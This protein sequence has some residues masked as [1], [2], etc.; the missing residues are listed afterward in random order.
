MNLPSLEGSLKN[1]DSYRRSSCLSFIF[2]IIAKVGFAVCGYLTYLSKTDQEITS[3]V[4]QYH[5]LPTLLRI[6]VMFF[7]YFTIPLQSYVV[8]ELIDSQ[9]RRKFPIW[10]NREYTWLC[11][12]RSLFMTL[13]LFVAVVI[14]DFSIVVSLIGSLR[15]SMISLVLPA[16]F[17]VR[18]QT[19]EVSG[20][21]KIACYVTAVFGT[22]AAFIGV[23]SSVMAI[24]VGFKGRK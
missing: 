2:N 21:K 13:C 23:F 15:G 17:Y 8:F 5:P 19:H 22:C 1:P 18:L 9:F 20:V 24:A 6:A 14:P 3:N 12:S 4:D 11:I 10:E 16:L 7:A